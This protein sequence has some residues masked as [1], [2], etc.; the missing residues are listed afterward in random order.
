MAQNRSES[1]KLVGKCKQCGQCCRNMFL[2]FEIPMK[3]K[4]FIR[5]DFNEF[6]ESLIGAHSKKNP[7]LDF[8]KVDEIKIYRMPE[9]RM[10]GHIYGVNCRALKK[11]GKK[12]FCLFHN[13]KP[14]ICKNYPVESSSKFFKGCGFKLIRIKKKVKKKNRS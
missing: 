4:D 9:N 7:H 3:H 12:Y 6:I 11:R 13:D 1:V 10:R 2:D 5:E 8:S 14:A